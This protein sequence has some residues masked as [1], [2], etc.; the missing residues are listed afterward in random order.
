MPSQGDVLRFDTIGDFDDVDEI[1]GTYQVKYLDPGDT[2]NE[3]ALTDFKGIFA[4][5]WDIIK[6]LHSILV[7]V[8]RIRGYNVTTSQLMGESAFGTPLEGTAIGDSL[9]TQATIPITFKTR[10]PKIMLRKL[11]GP[12]S[13]AN[14]E[15]DGR[16]GA[17]VATALALAA[18]FMMDDLV[19]GGRSYE[20]GYQSPIA[21]TWDMV[22]FHNLE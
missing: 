5:L 22:I 8:R 17:G 14:I 19:S 6:S 12:A 9:I 3:A 1:V 4:D 20:Y 13:E 7:T 21:L 11:W 18:T 16:Y 10:Y 15:A 2:S